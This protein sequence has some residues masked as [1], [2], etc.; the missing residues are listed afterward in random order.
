VIAAPKFYF[1]DVGVVNHLTKRGD[2]K[3][4]S[5]L[6]GKA[7]ENWVFHELCAHNAYR[8]A[9]A[10]LAYWRLAGGTEV[11][12]VVND[13]QVAIEAKAAGKIT[14]DHLKG[15]RAVT[16]DHRRVKERVVVCLEPKP[17]RTEDGILIL[18]ATEFSQRLE[19]LF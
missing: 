14:S 15:L 12:F 10:T 6:Y 3:P 16:Q 1:A 7:F 4:G 17:R 18:P 5:E 11:D 13:M 9:F 8:E 2:L 19:D